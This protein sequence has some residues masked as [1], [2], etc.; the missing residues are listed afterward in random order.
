MPSGSGHRMGAES[1]SLGRRCGGSGRACEAQRPAL[2]P[3]P[4]HEEVIRRLRDPDTTAVTAGPSSALKP[5]LSHSQG[6]RG[7]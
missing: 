2:P 7:P 1:R 3:S 6:A 5:P 4:P